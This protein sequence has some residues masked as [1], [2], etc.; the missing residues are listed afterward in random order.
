MLFRSTSNDSS[1]ANTGSSGTLTSN[2]SSA[3]NT[4]GSG[5]LTSNGPSNPITSS[6]STVQPYVTCYMWRRTA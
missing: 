6:S 4:G 5:T 1:A 2:G 3:A